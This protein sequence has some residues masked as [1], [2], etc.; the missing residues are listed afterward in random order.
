MI[1]CS[2]QDEV[3][4]MHT[5][6]AKCVISWLCV[7]FKR[8]LGNR[9]S[10]C[11]HFT[12]KPS[13]K[14]S[15][16]EKSLKRVFNIFG[17]VT[18]LAHRHYI[19]WCFFSFSPTSFLRTCCSAFGLAARSQKSAGYTHRTFGPSGPEGPMSHSRKLPA[20][21]HSRCLEGFSQLISDIKEALIVQER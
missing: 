1:L 19:R 8:R 7:S 6:V 13:N 17:N 3:I 10:C 4:I 11:P 2:L 20:L 16:L 14:V 12:Q 9:S 5:F 15:N 21:H 18:A